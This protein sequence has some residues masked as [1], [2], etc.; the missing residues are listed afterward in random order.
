MYYNG[1]AAGSRYVISRGATGGPEI[2]L[3]SDGD[4]NLNRASN[5]NVLIGGNATF[6]N[7]ATVDGVFAAED[8]V[9]FNGLDSFADD[10]AAAAAGI[11]KGVVYQTDGSGAPPLN[12]AGIL[13]VKQ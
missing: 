11:A 5:G 13:M 12:V 1:V 8:A 7:D 2:E 6:N 4:I 3:E 9:F 10:A